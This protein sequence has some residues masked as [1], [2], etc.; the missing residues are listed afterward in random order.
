MCLELQQHQPA[1]AAGRHR[2]CTG[3][4]TNMRSVLQLRCPP[5]LMK[6]TF[7]ARLE[8]R[9]MRSAGNSSSSRTMMTLPTSTSVQGMS[10]TEPAARTR[11][12]ASG[13]APER[14]TL[15]SAA[16]PMSSGSAGAFRNR[17]SSSR[18]QQ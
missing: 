15:S 16:L 11:T 8:Y 17:G 7:S 6:H 14:H 4:V 9:H 2:G 5:T 10:D 18:K 1:V 3:Q 13:R 12:Q